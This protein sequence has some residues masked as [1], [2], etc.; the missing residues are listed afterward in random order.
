M[1]VSPS[2]SLTWAVPRDF[3]EREV[4]VILTV[5]DAAGQEVF[6]TFRL[7]VKDG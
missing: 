4:T 1:K 2:G 5:R 3:G 6:H 7:A